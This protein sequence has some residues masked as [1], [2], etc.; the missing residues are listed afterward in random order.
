MVSHEG[1][2]KFLHSAA[3]NWGYAARTPRIEGFTPGAKTFPPYV[4]ETA[5]GKLTLN[6]VYFGRSETGGMSV[7]SHGDKPIL[8]IQYRGGCQESIP[9]DEVGEI[10]RFL[11]QAL[12]TNSGRARSSFPGVCHYGSLDG[13]YYYIG[14]GL[15]NIWDLRWVDLIFNRPF[16]MSASVLARKVDE[17]GEEFAGIMRNHRF[18]EKEAR[19]M[20]SSLSTEGF[21]SYPSL[22]FYH[23]LSHQRI[24]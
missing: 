3:V 10:N 8:L 2:E 22:A 6:D 15:G 11:Q 19:S 4:E 1:L 13:D 20:F 14:F 16:P 9:S 17:T 21:K 12:H 7:V 24:V 18:W 23:V 5:E